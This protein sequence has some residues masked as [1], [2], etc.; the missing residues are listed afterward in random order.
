M[1]RIAYGVLALLTAGS[2]LLPHHA[3]AQAAVEA[4]D[5]TELPSIKSAAQAQRVISQSYPRNLQTAGISG[6]VQVRFIVGADG[7]VAAGSVEIL[8]TNS[9]AL[10]E[11]AAQAVSGIEF[12]PGKKDG[13]AV[14]AY[15]VMPIRYE[16]Q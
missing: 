10:G 4:K 8:A 3:S 11:A 5:L 1:A 7:K 13:A 14:A 6:T 15:V 2:F 9:Q 16:A 12:N